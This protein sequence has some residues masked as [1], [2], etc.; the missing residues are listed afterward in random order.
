MFDRARIF[1]K[2]GS[3]GDGS[4]HMRREM[5]VP[6]GGPD[7]GDGGR[8]GSIYVEADRHLN[9]LGNFAHRSHFKA[10]SGER[11][12]RQRQQG[13]AGDD[14]TLTVPPGRSS[15][16]AVWSDQPPATLSHISCSR[17][18]S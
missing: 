17:S 4:P 10:E 14:L 1:V 5:Y 11:G 15:M 8:G 13:G 2:A 12:S 3:G 16:N 7:G 9:T 18:S 6:H